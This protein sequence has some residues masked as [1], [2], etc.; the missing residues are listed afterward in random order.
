MYTPLTQEQFQAAQKAG[1][2][3]DKII[4]MEQQRKAEQSAPAAPAAPA[5]PTPSPL[6]TVAD[7]A[8]GALGIAAKAFAPAGAPAASYAMSQI[9]KAPGQ[10][11][12]AFKGGLG[13]MQQGFTEGARGDFPIKPALKI[14]TG[15]INAVSAPIAPAFAPLGAAI[16]AVGDKVGDIPAVQKFSTSKAGEATASITEDVGNASTLLG[17][18]AG[19]KSPLGQTVKE[20]IPNPLA[21]KSEAQIEANITTKFDKGVKPLLGARATPSSVGRYKA[22][23]ITAVKTIKENIPNLSYSTDAGETITGSAPKSLQ[24]LTDALEQTKKTIFTKYDAL[25]QQAGNAGMKVDM[26]PIATELDPVINN[27]ALSITN[28]KAIDYAIGL[29][30]RLTKAGGLDATTAQEVVQNYNKS[31]EAFYRNPSYDTAS[32]AAIDAMIANRMRKALDEGI[33]GL[34][35]EQY[36]TLKSQYGALKTIER[37]VIKATLRDARKNTKGMIDFTDIFSGGQVVHG[38]LALNPATVAQGFAAKGIAE[39]YKHL[40]NPNKA[41]ERMFKEADQLPQSQ[42]PNQSRLQTA[43]SATSANAPSINP[44]GGSLPPTK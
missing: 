16:N 13:Q 32:H 20:S 44:M 1:F 12:D 31:L 35:G 9:S 38:I 3:T 8:K 6:G 18:M 14:M 23:V 10:V 26:K 7:L 25:A 4:E 42:N 41:I 17:T 29:K 36:Q 15:G 21:A 22:D 5:A 19:V 40:N 27:K 2:S 33:T 34:T 37:D 24:Q 39:L 30:T 28:P 11:A 43:A